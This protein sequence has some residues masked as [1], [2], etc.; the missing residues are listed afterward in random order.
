MRSFE[1]SSVVITGGAT[2]IGFA[3][4]KAFGK[5]GARVMIAEPRQH[6]LEEAVASLREE[7]IKALWRSCDVTQSE[8]IESLADSA[9]SEFGEVDVLINNAGI[10]APNQPVTELNI[11]DLH[12]VFDVNFFGMW[13]GTAIFG[14]RMIEQGRRASLYSVGS[15]LSFFTRCPMPLPTWRQSTQYSAWS[16]GFVRRCQTSSMSA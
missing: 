11:K 13:R 16:K 8:E 14:K 4:A 6:R 12:A 7:G 2:G 5:E 9:W 3:L 10:K 15:V 1:H